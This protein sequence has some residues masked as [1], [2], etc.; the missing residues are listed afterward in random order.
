[1]VTSSNENISVLLAL[2]ARNS[3]V[4]GDFPHVFHIFPF[5]YSLIC[6]WLHGWVSHRDAGNL[7]RHRAHHDVTERGGF[8]DSFLTVDRFYS[9]MIDYR[10]ISVSLNNTLRLGQNGR[11]FA[12]IFKCIFWNENVWIPLRISRKLVPKGPVNT[13]P[14]LD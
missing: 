11:H 5:M 13:I 4:I 8:T 6:A 10:F 1:M 12:N 2:C 3:L 14:A 9:V 7:R